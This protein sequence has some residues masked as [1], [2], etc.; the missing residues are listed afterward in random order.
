MN[1]S[2]L[3]AA[4][5]VPVGPLI[6]ALSFSFYFKVPHDGLLVLVA[7]LVAALYSEL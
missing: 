1:L 2:V 6:V 4:L 7:D 5:L 3:H